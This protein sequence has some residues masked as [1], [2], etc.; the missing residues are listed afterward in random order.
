MQ[1]AETACKKKTM[2]RT[3]SRTSKHVTNESTVNYRDNGAAQWLHVSCSNI[4]STVT[5]WPPD[6]KAGPGLVPKKWPPSDHGDVTV[7]FL[8]TVVGPTFLEKQMV[9]CYEKHGQMMKTH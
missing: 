2:S 3:F 4:Q 7:R 6:P 1:A 9:L 8:E 5:K